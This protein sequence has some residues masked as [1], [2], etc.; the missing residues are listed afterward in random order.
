MN[1]SNSIKNIAAALLDAQ[2]DLEPILLNASNPYFKS[3]YPDAGQVTEKVNKALHKNDLVFLCL[4]ATQPNLNG[5]AAFSFLLIHSLS[6]EWIESETLLPLG[7]NKN[8]AHAFGALMTYVIRR[9]NLSLMNVVGEEDDDANSLSKTHFVPERNNGH[10]L[11]KEIKAEDLAEV[12]SPDSNKDIPK[13]VMIGTMLK[14]AAETAKPASQKQ[15]MLLSSLLHDVFP[16]NTVRQKVCRDIYD[17]STWSKVSDEMV[18]AT[19]NWMK[20]TLDPD[21][22]QYNIPITIYHELKRAAAPYQ[23]V[24]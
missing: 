12:T 7:D 10:H 14:Q 2:K 19:L 6:G 20:P 22:K 11:P 18:M 17:T 1:K 23:N 21:D 16:D 8:I 9:T 3:R 13:G 24:G 15:R 4:P 5:T